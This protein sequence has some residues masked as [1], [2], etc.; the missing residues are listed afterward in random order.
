ME[1]ADAYRLVKIREGEVKGKVG[2]FRN[3]LDQGYIKNRLRD[4]I[5]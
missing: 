2:Q 1:R 3:E 5:E 4:K